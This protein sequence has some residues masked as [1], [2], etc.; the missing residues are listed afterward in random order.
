MLTRAGGVAAAFIDFDD[1]RD[2]EDAVRKMDGEGKI[3]VSF[4][5]VGGLRVIVCVCVCVVWWIWEGGQI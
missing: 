1:Y 3:I 2:A 4:Y 5:D